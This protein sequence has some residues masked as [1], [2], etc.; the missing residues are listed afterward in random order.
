MCDE[1]RYFFFPSRAYGG[2]GDDPLP[3]LA[4]RWAREV[5]GVD[6]RAPVYRATRP[7]SPPADITV[8][9]GVGE[10]PA[11]RIDGAFERDY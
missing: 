5:F 6:G 3:D 10:N 7:A 9:L 2:D 4:A 1:D 8:S 11:K